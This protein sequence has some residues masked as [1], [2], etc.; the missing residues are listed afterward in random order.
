M[1]P[2][3]L[4]V[5]CATLVSGCMAEASDVWIRGGIQCED[6]WDAWTSESGYQDV[7]GSPAEVREARIAAYYTDLG[8]SVQKVESEQ[9]DG[10]FAAVCGNH[11]GWTD[12]MTVSDF[13]GRDGWQRS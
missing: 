4:V 8:F 12:R 7:D 6:P 10:A 5:A 1:R 2:L 13:D 3:L 9:E 11:N